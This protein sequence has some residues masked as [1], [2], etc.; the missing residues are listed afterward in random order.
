M[1][2]LSIFFL[3]IILC[4]C[5]SKSQAEDSNLDYYGDFDMGKTVT[6]QEY[7]EALDTIK[8]L[9]ENRGRMPKPKKKPKLSKEDKM[10]QKADEKDVHANSN[11]LVRPYMLFALPCDIYNN[12]QIVPKG[13]YNAVYKKDENNK[14]WLFLKQ[15]HSVIASLSLYPS[16]QEPENDKLYYI[17]TKTLDTSYI[18][19]MYGEIEKHFEN[20]FQIAK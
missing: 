5:T 18:K 11:I 8:S 20:I 9:N 4:F 16:E 10:I 2:K 19:I 14:D 15:G 1:K 12:R 3:I 13:Y 7:Q 6:P 17:E